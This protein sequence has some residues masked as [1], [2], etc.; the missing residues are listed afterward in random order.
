[1][2]IYIYIV[3]Y[4]KKIGICM[5]KY[6]EYVST[7]KYYIYIINICLPFNNEVKHTGLQQNPV[8]S[9]K[10]TGLQQN[11]QSLSQDS[12]PRCSLKDLVVG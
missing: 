9:F 11:Q 12:L 6:D 2:C 3:I 10:H 7:Y 5:C 8:Q 1:M 4:V